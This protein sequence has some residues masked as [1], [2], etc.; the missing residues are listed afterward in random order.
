MRATLQRGGWSGTGIE[1]VE[2]AATLMENC[3]SDPSI[4]LE[5]AIACLD[6][7]GVVAEF[8]AR[9][10]Y[11][12]TGRDGLGWQHAGSNGLPFCVDKAEWLAYLDRH[13]AG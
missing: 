9:I 5:D 1:L 7:P 12:R 4:R 10:L 3:E 13:S 6:Y 2:A 11:A 8:G